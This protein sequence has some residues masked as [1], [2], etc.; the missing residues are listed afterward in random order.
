MGLLIPGSWVRAPHRAHSFFSSYFLL[1][2]SFFHIFPPSLQLLF[3]SIRF[4]KILHSLHFFFYKTG[5][6]SANEKC[7]PNSL[8]FNGSIVVLSVIKNLWNGSHYISLYLDRSHTHHL[9]QLLTKILQYTGEKYSQTG[10]NI[11]TVYQLRF[12][13]I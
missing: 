11:V 7:V 5:K 13:T 2:S 12:R 3:L 1:F 10:S 4:L 9:Q 6:P 8:Q